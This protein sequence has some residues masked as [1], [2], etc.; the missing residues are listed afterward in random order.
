MP[1]TTDVI[2]VSSTSSAAT[3]PGKPYKLSEADEMKLYANKY[4]TKNHTAKLRKPI[5]RAVSKPHTG[6]PKLNPGI[7]NDL[8]NEYDQLNTGSTEL[9][10]HN[11]NPPPQSIQLR[12][13]IRQAKLNAQRNN[14]SEITFG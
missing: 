9:S 5:G 12:Q 2:G 3:L 4:N 14:K 6:P 8:A 1:N 10:V 11:Q 7:L 13:Q